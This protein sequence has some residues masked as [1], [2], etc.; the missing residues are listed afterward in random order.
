[1]KKIFIVL[2]LSLI[3]SSMNIMG[4]N[5]TAY[6]TYASFNVPS[7]TPYIET[8]ISVIGNSVKF[9][10]N[11]NGKYQGAIDI[12]VAF[13]QNGVIKN[14]QKYTL[15]S[16]EIAD[17]AKEFVNFLDQQRYSL[18]SGSYDLEISIADKNNPT[19]KPFSNKIPVVV[20]FPADRVMVSDIQLL[21]SFTKSQKPGIL[22]KSGYDLVPYVS[23]FYPENINVLRFYSEIYNAKKILGDSSKMIV[24]YFL[25]NYDTKA[26][27]SSFSAFSKQS[28]N[29]VNIL[30][31]EFNIKDLPSG[32]YNLVIEV[33]DRENKIQAEQKCF[34]QRQA[35][36]AAY[37]MEDLKTIDVSKTFVSKLTNQD[38][39]SE[40]IRCLRPVSSSSEVQF[41]ENQLKNKDLKLMQQFFFNF[42]KSRNAL[43][44]EAAWEEYSFE[45]SKV[46]KQFGTYGLKGYD[47]D[48]GRVYL[49]YGAPDS[50]EVSNIEPSAY[51]YELWQYN[52]LI[53][54]AQIVNSPN[55][56]QTN[57]R[58]VFYNPDMVTNKYYLLHSDA[59]GER[60]NPRWQLDLYKRNT[61][62]TIDE[63]RAPDHFGGKVNENFMNPK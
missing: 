28:P 56:R 1:M 3:G 37:N 26:K 59:R 47:T 10:K 58:F 43:S 18:E 9:V 27:L 2:L 5:I 55:N 42:W 54:K 6:L 44:P 16:P 30:M 13:S 63:Q 51:P 61:Q 60:N 57:R 12:S 24:S 41:A 35:A 7:Q 46:N 45:V 32:S 22:T 29:E 25:E 40:Y 11:S 33:R 39:L 49:Q 62:S 50:R 19:V 8:Y 17:T 4:G 20:N 21:E 23:T 31:S 53:D 38:T 14:A 36:I 34:I 48:R 15:N 52:S